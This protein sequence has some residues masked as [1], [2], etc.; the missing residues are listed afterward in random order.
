MPGY[1]FKGVQTIMSQFFIQKPV[2]VGDVK[3]N[4]FRSIVVM[5]A[6]VYKIVFQI[7][8]FDD[9]KTKFEQI[10]FLSQKTFPW[11]SL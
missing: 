2:E 4:S 9:S 10:C 7:L 3:K 5:L 6:I 8:D 11:H 1:I